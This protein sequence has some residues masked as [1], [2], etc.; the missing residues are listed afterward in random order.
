[1]IMSNEKQ[2][3]VETGGFTTTFNDI[4][5]YTIKGKK[6]SPESWGLYVFMLSLPDNW[7]YT[8]L[9]LT[10]VVN[11]GRDKIQ[12]MLKELEIAGFLTRKQENKGR[13][14]KIQYTIH[15]KSKFS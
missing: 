8:I 7:D 14:G 10:K 9:G 13:F 15:Q 6:L 2:F 11:S 1:M 4:F 12:R 3:K 5:R